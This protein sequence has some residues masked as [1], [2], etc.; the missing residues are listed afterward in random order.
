MN[1][2]IHSRLVTLHDEAGNGNARICTQ[3]NINTASEDSP[4]KWHGDEQKMHDGLNE[5]VG[6][7]NVSPK[8]RES[9]RKETGRRA[10]KT[11]MPAEQ[12]FREK[13]FLCAQD[14]IPAGPPPVPEKVCPLSHLRDEIL[15]LHERR[16]RARKRGSRVQGRGIIAAV[17][18][19]SPRMYARPL[20]IRRKGK[21]RTRFIFGIFEG[22]TA[23]KM[24]SHTRIRIRVIAI[25][26]TRAHTR[27]RT[28]C[29]LVIPYRAKK[30]CSRS[31]S[32]RWIPISGQKGWK[33]NEERK[34]ILALRAPPLLPRY[35]SAVLKQVRRYTADRRVKERIAIARDLARSRE[36]RNHSRTRQHRI[37]FRS[38]AC[39]IRVPPLP[40]RWL[41]VP[42]DPESVRLFFLL[43]FFF[44]KTEDR[45]RAFA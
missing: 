11:M 7:L 10:G 16:T 9:Q 34:Y 8:G 19:R 6:L 17:A 31:H 14:I 43:F 21:K 23:G 26:R 24:S 45:D 36:Y 42:I 25:H 20:K 29:A 18:A 30:S 28:L 39:Q 40:R 32:T 3:R 5:Q 38:L 13:R 4:R 33:K 2:G 44:L 12:K 37:R 41:P 1:K 35:S 15:M 22:R 27:T